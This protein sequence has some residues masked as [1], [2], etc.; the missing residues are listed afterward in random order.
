MFSN[1][2]KLFSIGGF[3]IKFDPSWLIVAALIAWSLYQG[4][5]PNTLPGESAAV[6]LSMS[7]AATVLFFASL[8][9]H[10]LAHSFVA[11]RFGLTVGGITM[12]LFGGVAELEKEPRSPEVEF[13]VAIAGPAMSLAL[14]AS[15]LFMSWMVAFAGQLGAVTEVLSYLA[16]INLVLALFNLVPAFPLDGGRILRAYLWHRTGNLLSATEAAARSGVIFAFVLMGLGVLSLFKDK[17]FRSC[18]K[19]EPWA[20]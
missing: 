3:E 13:F 18:L 15:F 20:T 14:A 1:A 2:V 12:F 17:W 10:E 6:Y 9:L 11:R 16:A 8:I 5:F 19:D 4:Y 7:V